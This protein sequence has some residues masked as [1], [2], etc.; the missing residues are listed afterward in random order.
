[1][2]DYPARVVVNERTG[3]VVSGGN[4]RIS[5]ITIT[6]GD[7]NVTIS[8]EFFVSQPSFIYRGSSGVRSIVVPNTDIVVEEE[9]PIGVNLPNSSTV[10]ELV[11]A[12]NQVR[13]TSRDVITILQGIKRA[14]A[15]HAE[16][17]VQ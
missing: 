10:A 14:G 4:V 2:P 3:T 13:A 11:T 12:L 5:P 6:H 9:E 15:L 16:L 8:T 17:V 7:L 1:M